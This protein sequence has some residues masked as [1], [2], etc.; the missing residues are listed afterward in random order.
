MYLTPDEFR[1]S[2]MGTGKLIKTMDDVELADYLQ[3]AKDLIDAHCD[4]DFSYREEPEE[5]RPWKGEGY[6][7]HPF[8]APVR[9]VQRYW[10]VTGAYSGHDFSWDIGAVPAGA[11]PTL[12]GRTLPPTTWGQ[13]KLNRSLN[14]L[15]AST[16][17]IS[18]TGIGALA[19]FEQMY[20]G[21]SYTS[22]YDEGTVQA[23]GYSLPYPSWLKSAA[24]WVT[25]D[26]IIDS[27]LNSRGMGGLQEI[28]VAD[29][30][31]RKP[32]QRGRTSQYDDPALNP[33]ARRILD[34]HQ[35]VWAAG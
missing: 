21:L 15:D 18:I 5:L 26:I 27:G 19:D 13:V 4:N 1:R 28:R 32:T 29:T 22:G 34:R 14:E 3:Q 9:T 20:I 7:V 30:L 31:Y 2:P 35:T 10:L 25:R 12:L 33:Q 17:L 11:P 24:R 23:D 8:Y 16:W 6:T